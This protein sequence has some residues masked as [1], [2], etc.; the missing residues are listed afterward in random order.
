LAHLSGLILINCISEEHSK[1][2]VSLNRIRTTEVLCF[3]LLSRST[4]KGVISGVTTDVQV[5]YLKIIPGVVGAQRLT[6]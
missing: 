3:E 2:A 5:E 6:R 4:V 1:I